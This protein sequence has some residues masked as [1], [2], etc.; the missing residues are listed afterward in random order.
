MKYFGE[1]FKR[2]YLEERLMLVLMV[3]NLVLSLILIVFALLHL[4]PDA[5]VVKVGYGAIGGYRD[6]VWT[7]MIAFPILGL[8]FSVFHNLIALKIFHKRGAGMTKFFL[9]VT[10]VL[11]VSTFIVLIRLLGEG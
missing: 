2:I 6:G 10:S 9:I 4:S 7:D 3:A 11:I 1:D 5:S 8:I